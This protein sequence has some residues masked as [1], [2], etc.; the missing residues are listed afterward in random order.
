MGFIL[1]IYVHE[2][3]HVAALRRTGIAASAPMFIPFVGAFVRLKQPPR[4]P[5]EDATVG[6]AGPVYGLA[7]ALAC[8]ALFTLTGHSL[9]GAIARAGAWINLFNLIPVW[10][11]DGG[12]G[13]AAM[14]RVQRA[15]M[16]ALVAL[17]WVVSG[18]SLLLLLLLGCGYQLLKGAVVTRPSTR[19]E[20]TYA[21]LIVCLTALSQITLPGFEAS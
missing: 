20:W 18:E 7:A 9:I 14:T 11:L 13:F 8:Y 3:G 10:Q 1:S 16:S 5:E 17:A 2:M 6:L 4:T 21:A 15:R 19:A 12:R